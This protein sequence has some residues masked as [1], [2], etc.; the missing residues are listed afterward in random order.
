MKQYVWSLTYT[1]VLLLA[2]VSMNAQT[3]IVSGKVL[4]ADGGSTLPGAN[5]FLKAN[6]GYGTITDIDGKFNL[7]GVPV[8]EQVIVVSYL[9]YETKEVTVQLEQGERSVIDVNLSPSSIMGQEV[10]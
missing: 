10:V 2:S 4:D 9:G 5:V 3:A 7:T 8:G 6:T 1:I